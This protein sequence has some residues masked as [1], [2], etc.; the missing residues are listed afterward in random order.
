MTDVT[1]EAFPPV[2]AHL[3][4]AANPSRVVIPIVDLTTL[5]GFAAGSAAADWS[6][7][8]V[9]TAELSAREIDPSAHWPDFPGELHATVFASGFV[10]D[11]E[12]SLH[13]S[14]AHVDGEL[15][16]FP[17]SLDTAFDRQFDSTWQVET[18]SLENGPNSLSLGRQLRQ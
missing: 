9:W 14:D 7:D 2:G 6:N 3:R 13:V 15:R 1:G 12:W 11:G 16:G 17:F 10:S 8:V 4:G 18:F 5:T